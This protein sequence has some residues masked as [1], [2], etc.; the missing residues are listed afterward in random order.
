LQVLRFM[1]TLFPTDGSRYALAAA[2]F[3]SHWLPGPGVKVDL[4]SVIPGPERDVRPGYGKP[5]SVADRFRGE[6][7]RWQSATAEPLAAH[8]H[9]VN[10]VVREGVP[11]RVLVEMAEG[12]DYDL[13]VV[14]ARGRSETPHMR[15]GS[16]AQALLERAPPSVLMVREREPRERGKRLPSPMRPFSLMLPSDG[17]PHSLE[18]SRRFFRLFRIENLEVEIVTVVEEPGA[19]EVESVRPSRRE[20]LQAAAD[21]EAHVRLNIV[22][23]EL[24]GAPVRVGAR[25][26]RGEPAAQVVARA[27]EI[28]AD[29]LVLGSRGIRAP[30]GRRVGSVALEI[31]RSAP[32]SVLVVREP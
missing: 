26:L 20:H 1:K 19:E 25:V 9:Q 12:G 23:N 6:A 7:A 17:E 4:V 24:A 30:E 29:L 18:A 10:A 15:M 13:V 31:A 2:R 8:G 27:N 14:G 32:C 28:E 11:S 22:E 3:L 21:R 16:V 5:R